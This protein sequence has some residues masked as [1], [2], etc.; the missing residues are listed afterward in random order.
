MRIAITQ[1]IINHNGNWLDSIGHDWYGYLSDHDL[2]VIPNRYDLDLKSVVNAHDL[3]II[4]GG[5]RHPIRDWVEWNI[6]ELCLAA[7]KPVLGVCHGFQCLTMHHGGSI[8]HIDQHMRT[9]HHVVDAQ[10][11]RHWVNSY[12][13]FRVVSV[14]RNATCLAKD[15]DGNCESWIMGRQ[16]GVMWHPERGPAGWLPDQ[17]QLLIS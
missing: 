11:D 6:I 17:L 12:H 7:N 9:G 15:E 13:T 14:P 5:E 1:R 16:G 10:G 2:Y 3:I 4:S 8:E